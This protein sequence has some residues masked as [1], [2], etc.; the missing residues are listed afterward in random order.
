[1]AD[2]HVT[3]GLL[4]HTA[5]V[6]TESLKAI[7]EAESEIQALFEDGSFWLKKGPPVDDALPTLIDFAALVQ[8]RVKVAQTERL[9]GRSEKSKRNERRSKKVPVK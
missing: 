4:N 8:A 1:M 5:S 2:V 7:Q 9:F 6:L 3:K